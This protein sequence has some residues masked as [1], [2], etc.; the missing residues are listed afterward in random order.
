MALTGIKDPTYSKPE[1]DNSRDRVNLLQVNQE[2]VQRGP[3]S[4]L[5]VP[6]P[7]DSFSLF[8]SHQQMLRLS[9]GHG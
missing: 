6:S 2:G 4:G 5:R 1:Q 7:G 8:S 9:L 3:A